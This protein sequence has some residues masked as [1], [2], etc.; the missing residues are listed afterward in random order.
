[1]LIVEELFGQE[2]SFESMLGIDDED[3]E[4]VISV[5]EDYE[6]LKKNKVTKSNKLGRKNKNRKLQD[7]DPTASFD[8][9]VEGKYGKIVKYSS[10][11]NETIIVEE[12]NGTEDDDDDDGDNIGTI[13]TESSN[14]IKFNLSLLVYILI[15][16]A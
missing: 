2:G 8:I 5:D 1:M 11:S 7:D 14:F 3:E 9:T 12:G 10:S 4:E 6:D 15:L 13:S 16:L